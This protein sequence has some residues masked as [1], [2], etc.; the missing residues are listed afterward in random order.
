MEI[1][2]LLCIIGDVLCIIGDRKK[3]LTR[4]DTDEIQ[5]VKK[6]NNDLF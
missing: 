3:S 5:E 1:G 6:E 4:G 2:D